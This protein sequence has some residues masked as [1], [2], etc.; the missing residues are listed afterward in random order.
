[1][2]GVRLCT[3]SQSPEMAHSINFPSPR[4]WSKCALVITRF[5]SPYP[6]G[7]A[8]EKEPTGLFFLA[9]LREAPLWL[10]LRSSLPQRKKHPICKQQIG[11]FAIICKDYL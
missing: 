6:W 9:H 2:L 3:P 1:M 5:I 8:S 10:K 4:I 7:I 11:C